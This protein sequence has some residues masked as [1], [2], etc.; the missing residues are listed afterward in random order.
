[1]A[2]NILAK[3]Y[4]AVVLQN[5]NGSSISNGAG[6]AAGTANLDNRSGGITGAEAFFAHFELLT[7]GFGSNPGA[8]KNVDLYLVPAVDGTNFGDVDSSIPNAQY[9][10]GSF[11]TV[12]SG[13]AKRLSLMNVPIGP[14]LLKAY[15]VNNTG[16][17]LSANWGLR[18]VLSSEQYT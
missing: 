5:D 9:F 2:G 18:V 1:M 6:G 10:V 12:N 4:S 7:A 11:I 17:T 13:S 14:L 15:L 16:Q 8:G 3:E